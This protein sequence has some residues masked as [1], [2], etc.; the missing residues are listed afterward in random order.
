MNPNLGNGDGTEPG[1]VSGRLDDLS[2]SGRHNGDGE[3]RG[4]D[5]DPIGAL[6]AGPGATEE[7]GWALVTDGREATGTEGEWLA[8]QI[9]VVVG[10]LLQ[11][12]RHDRY[13]DLSP[14]MGKGE[15]RDWDR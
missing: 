2:P 3:R 1:V 12:A 11:W 13:L 7:P 9:S 4:H 6:A 10:E 5:G 14:V 8:E 15:R